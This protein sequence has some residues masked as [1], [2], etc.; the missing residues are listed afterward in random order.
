MVSSNFKL[1][2]PILSFLILSIP[3]D[4]SHKQCWH[5]ALVPLVG[6]CLTSPPA[7]QN[8][9]CKR[10]LSLTGHKGTAEEDERLRLK[11]IEACSPAEE[12][13]RLRVKSPSSAGKYNLTKH[14][15]YK[16]SC[17]GALYR[18]NKSI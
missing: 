7:C 5:T 14:I 17:S 10:P 12:D 1:S 15:L 9:T 4:T 11:D 13:K 18:H 16:E 8:R 3:Y 6:V 2:R